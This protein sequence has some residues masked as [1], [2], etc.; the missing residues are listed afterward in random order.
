MP[1]S[2]ETGI[3][4]LFRHCYCNLIAKFE[5]SRCAVVV[6]AFREKHEW[7]LQILFFVYFNIGSKMSNLSHN[8]SLPLPLRLP[9][10][11]MHTAG[12]GLDFYTWG[13]PTTMVLN[14]GTKL[15]KQSNAPPLI[16]L[17]N[18]LC[19]SDHCHRTQFKFVLVDTKGYTGG[20]TFSYRNEGN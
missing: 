11:D 3:T 19:L 18:T 7:A 10:S 15:L 17:L 4:L 8:N 5:G 1:K 9:T 6:P 14:V 2:N 12:D 13:F 20:I 16:R